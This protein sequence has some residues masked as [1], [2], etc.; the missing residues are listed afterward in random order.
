MYQAIIYSRLTLGKFEQVMFNLLMWHNETHGDEQLGANSKPMIWGLYEFLRKFQSLTHS[1]KQNAGVLNIGPYLQRTSSLQSFWL[2]G[3]NH[4]TYRS[5]AHCGCHAAVMF[6]PLW[7]LSALGAVATPTHS[8]SQSGGQS[9]SWDMGHTTESA[10][11][12]LPLH[13]GPLHLWARG[14]RNTLVFGL[15]QNS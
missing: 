15:Q 2:L 1:Y 10:P 13:S 4:M 8:I 3:P 9:S 14:T 12:R 7:L 6:H 11:P 5:H